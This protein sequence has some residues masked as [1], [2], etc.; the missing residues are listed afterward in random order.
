LLLAN[1]TVSRVGDDSPDKINLCRDSGVAPKCYL[2]T[3]EI[4]HAKKG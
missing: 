3:S 4:G 2:K 1:G